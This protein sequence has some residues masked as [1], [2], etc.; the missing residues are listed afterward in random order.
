M[1]VTAA[2]DSLTTRSHSDLFGIKLAFSLFI[3]LLFLEEYTVVNC[4]QHILGVKM[5][6]YSTSLRM[7]ESL[8]QDIL[9]IAEYHDRKP[10]WVMLRALERF[11][12]QEKAEIELLKERSRLAQI[13]R[14]N[15]TLMSADEAVQE[16]KAYVAGFED[17]KH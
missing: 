5:S 10:H 11:A 13:E 7:P 1:L 3:A 6:N 14:E 17:A 9:E 4:T 2:A 16:M 12:E 15:G 8:K